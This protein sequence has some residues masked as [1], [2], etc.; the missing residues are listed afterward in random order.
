M[1]AKS[2]RLNIGCGRFPKVGFWNVD[3]ATGPGVDE[4]ADLS[5]FPFPF[6][7][8]SF[9]EIHADHV[10]EHLSDAFGTMRELHRI[11]R[12]GGRLEIRVPHF[13]RGFTH[14]EH[15]RGFD[16]TFPYYF[17]PDFEGGYTGTQFECVHVKMRWFAQPYL[18]QKIL[19]A[20]QFRFATTAGKLIDRAANWNPLICSRVWCFA[21]G[22]FEEIEFVF[23]KPY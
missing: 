3:W 10:L 19:S 21:V 20:G 16:A 9:D 22:G 23:R 17:Q 18:K 4:V 6:A 1:S 11:L 12:P 2:T 15:Q 14:A 8:G 13:S 7:D 5:T